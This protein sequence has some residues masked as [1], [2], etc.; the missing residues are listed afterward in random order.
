MGLYER[1]AGTESEKISSHA[2]MAALGEFDRGKM[3]SQQVINA[4]TLSSG[5]QTELTTLLS[6]FVIPPEVV[7][8]GGY[9]VLTNVG[10]T[11]DSSGP[12]KGLGFV[13]LET[14]GITGLEWHVRW[15]K[16]GTGTLSFQLWNETDGTELGV[17]NDAAA[18]GDN[19]SQ[20]LTITPG[21]PLDAGMKV[22]R[23]RA[24]S[25]VVADDPVYYGSTLRIRRVEKMTSVE[26]HE[27]LLLAREVIAPLNTVAALKS[28]L[29]V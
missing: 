17:I 29:G 18:A 1:L 28:R 22:L 11:Y 7:S 3:T 25:T 2:F 15:N 24:K 27:V 10:A 5:E 6:K 8:M 21:S 4:F 19:R 14:A 20:T 12:A 26:L 16:I 23:V 13:R 9:T